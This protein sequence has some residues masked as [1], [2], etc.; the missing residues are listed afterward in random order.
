MEENVTVQQLSQALNQL[1]D[2][3]ENLQNKNSDLKKELEDA[4][5]ENEELKEQVSL[6]SSTTTEQTSEMDAMIN[7]IESIL[8]NAPIMEEEKKEE[9]EPAETET[10]PFFDN[11][12]EETTEQEEEKKEET[13][14]DQPDLGRMQALLNGFNN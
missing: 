6:L 1:L 3:Y 12:L 7:R 11:S 10:S 8:S 5:L 14:K 4:Q 9:E 2:A 13:A